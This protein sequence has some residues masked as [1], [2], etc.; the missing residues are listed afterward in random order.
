MS[1]PSSSSGNSGN[2]GNVQP[3]NSDNVQPGSQRITRRITV[4]NSFAPGECTCHRPS[5]IVVCNACGFSEP[6][7]IRYSCPV[8]H[9]IIFVTDII[10][11]SKCKA[12]LDSL[13]EI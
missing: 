10:E 1:N 7:R 5:G 11:C 3:N 6:G 9:R 4:I 12:H 13:S 2:S 8:H